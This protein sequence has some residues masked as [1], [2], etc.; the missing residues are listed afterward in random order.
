MLVTAWEPPNAEGVGRFRVVKTGR[1]L[2]G[3]AEISVEPDGAG[4]RLDWHEDVV[5]R[6]LPF[7]RV[8]APVLGRASLWLYGR[9]VD[10]MV[11]RADER[12]R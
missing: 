4:A 1:L 6:P 2:G 12:H 5:V 11:A 3:W 9:A 10:G 8:F 7:K